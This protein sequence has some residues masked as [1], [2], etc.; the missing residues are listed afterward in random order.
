MSY[1]VILSLLKN[2]VLDT[3]AYTRQAHTECLQKNGA[4]SNI[5]KKYYILQLD[6]ALHK[7]AL[8]ERN[9]SRM[10]GYPRRKIHNTNVS[11]CYVTLELPMF[12]MTR[13]NVNF[14]V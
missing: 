8:Y 6:G 4:V 11:H 3:Y 13:Q 2:I 14:H 1:N 12:L 5:N 9:C 7:S 10:L